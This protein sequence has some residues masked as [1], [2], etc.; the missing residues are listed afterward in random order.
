MNISD[1]KGNLH[2]KRVLN[3]L[4]QSLYM[5]TDEKLNLLADKYEADDNVFAFACIE[6]GSVLGVIVV[7]LLAADSY[8]LLGIAVE[9]A[10]RGTGIGSKLI[11]AVVAHLSCRQICAETD[12]DAVGFYYNYGFNI[13]S[14][15]EK[16]PGIIRYL[17]TLKVS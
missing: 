1:I 2:D 10:F 4:S 12:D 3:V 11:S 7:R 17:C 8:E 15:G 6:A 14:L 16:Y 5:P 13:Q 9:S